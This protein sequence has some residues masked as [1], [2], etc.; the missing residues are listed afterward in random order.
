MNRE[1]ILPFQDKTIKLIL[2]GNFALT[3][4]IETVYDDAIL[5]TTRQKTSLIVFTR[6]QEIT[7]L[8]D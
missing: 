3:G 4:K 2:E 1:M 7:P 6:I 5:F 8:E